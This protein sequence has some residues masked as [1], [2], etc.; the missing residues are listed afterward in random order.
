MSSEQPIRQANAAFYDAF[1]HLDIKRMEEVWLREPYI[2]CAHPGWP[3]LSGWGP[4]MASWERIFEH[5]FEMRIL[6]ADTRIRVSTD[7]A[8]V[9]GTENIESRHDEGISHGVVFATNVFER[10]GSLW[11]LVHHHGSPVDRATEDSP[12]QLQ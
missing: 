2:T 5:T 6:F 4:I 7:L 11:Y 12:G 8:V 10:R 3:L 9:L 1:H